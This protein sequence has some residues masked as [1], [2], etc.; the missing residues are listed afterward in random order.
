MKKTFSAVVLLVLAS[1]AFASSEQSL[2]PENTIRMTAI[3][4]TPAKEIQVSA[5]TPI[6]IITTSVDHGDSLQGTVNKWRTLGGENERLSQKANEAVERMEDHNCSIRMPVYK[7]TTG[8]FQPR[9]GLAAITCVTAVGPV[10]VSE[11]TG[12]IVGADQMEGV[13][14]PKGEKGFFVTHSDIDIPVE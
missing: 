4:R 1:N 9:D 5:L 7:D 10:V 13:T 3:E 6:P 11:V 14:D 8:R 12:H 2:A